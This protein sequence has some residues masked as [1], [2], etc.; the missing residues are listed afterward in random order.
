MTI[1]QAI[2]NH[3]ITFQPLTDVVPASRIWVDEHDGNEGLPYVV[4]TLEKETPDTFS[5]GD[6]SFEAV[7]RF[8]AYDD[9]FE[10]GESLVDK[11]RQRFERVA[12]PAGDRDILQVRY[13]SKSRHRTEDGVWRWQLDYT[14]LINEA[15]NNG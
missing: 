10:R 5:S 1:E 2:R 14:L 9:D 11:V 13:T 12:M 15:T 4:L 7:V 6:R 3:W 8:N